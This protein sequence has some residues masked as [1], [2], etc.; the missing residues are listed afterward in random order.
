MSLHIKTLLE[1]FKGNLELAHMIDKAK[2]RL[3]NPDDI[4][5][6]IDTSILIA[7]QFREDYERRCLIL[8]H[9]LLTDC[10]L[11][12]IQVLVPSAVLFELW[13]VLSSR[14]I[15]VQT[16]SQYISQVIDRFVRLP[17]DY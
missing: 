13:T 6:L 7:T 12:D 8:L 14:Q 2:K 15:P 3:V 11:L 16:I 5:V 4:N 9:S 17:D 1:L 10:A